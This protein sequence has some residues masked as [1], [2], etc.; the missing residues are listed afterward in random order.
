LCVAGVCVVLIPGNW[1]SVPVQ[2]IAWKVER[3]T[4]EMTYYVLRWTLNP[5]HL[6]TI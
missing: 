3:L 2:L 1:L 4:S 6:L 5:T